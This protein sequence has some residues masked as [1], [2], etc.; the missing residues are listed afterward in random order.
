MY[1]YHYFCP[2]TR[3]IFWLSA[4]PSFLLQPP[5]DLKAKQRTFLL[6]KRINHQR[7]QK[8]P[9]RKSNRHLD[10]AV[11]HIELHGIDIHRSGL[12]RIADGG[13]AIHRRVCDLIRARHAADQTP[14]S[15]QAR[16]D[17]NEDGRDENS[18]C[19]TMTESRIHISRNADG[20][21]TQGVCDLGVGWEANGGE[22]VD[23]VPEEGDY[24]H[25]GHI[26][27]PPL[28]LVDDNETEGE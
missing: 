6:P 21:G 2:Y 18:H 11:S 8:Q 4:S 10:H 5:W 17:L 23:H 28:A 7:T 19:E 27:L 3:I 25:D 20:E 24:Y 15:G 14:A 12:R 22:M 13:G 1:R 26:L 9:D 16:G